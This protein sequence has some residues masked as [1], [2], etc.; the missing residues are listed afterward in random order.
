MT[1]AGKSV[2]MNRPVKSETAF[3]VLRKRAEE[4][5]RTQG[6][7]LPNADELDIMRLV[8]EVEVQ[9][10]ELEIQNEELRRATKELEASRNEYAELYQTAPVA[11]VTLNAKGII[12]KVN[13]AAARLFAGVG[14]ALPGRSF[15]TL[16][17]RKDQG[18]YFSQL[19]ELALS[20]GSGSCELRF[21]D[22]GDQ[23][24]H[25][26]MEAAARCDAKGGVI[27]W[28]LA[29]VDIS[30]R[31]Q[32]EQLLKQYRQ[33]LEREVASRTSEIEMQN[34]EL[35]QLNRHNRQLSQKTL[36]A[37]E[38]SRR[39]TSRMPISRPRSRPCCT[40]SFRRP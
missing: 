20:H 12:E 19:K 40:G 4:I 23:P 27:F 28:H 15:A 14:G 1:P 25:L 11:F 6:I 16:I 22:S 10:V 8:H 17:L 32:K 26:Q 31:K 3:G 9:H 33:E 38:S 34:R 2:G 7:G 5:I 18:I 39:S 13:A 36:A 24:I 35:E 29:L 37:S 30:E 21:L